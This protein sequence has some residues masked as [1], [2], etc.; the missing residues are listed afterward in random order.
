MIKSVTNLEKK[1]GSNLCETEKF[2]FFVLFC[3]LFETGVYTRFFFTAKP[4]TRFGPSRYI[5]QNPCYKVDMS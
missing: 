2:R 5:K 4:L 1:K 3:F